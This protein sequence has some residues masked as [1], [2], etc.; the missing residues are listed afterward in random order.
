[1]SNI[2]TKSLACLF[3]F[4][5]ILA[6]CSSPSPSGISR[7]PI[8]SSAVA[9]AT[10]SPT[11]S[12]VQHTEDI[13]YAYPMD[14]N[15]P[16][17][18][19]DVYAPSEIDANPVVVFL[20]GLNAN[21]NAHERE[22]RAL[23]ERGVLVFTINWPTPNSDLAWENNGRD[24]RMMAEAHACAIRYAR[25]RATDFGGDPTQ[26]IMV[27]FSMG[28]RIGITAALAGDELPIL[29]KEFAATRGGPPSQIECVENEASAKV[30][31][32]VGIGGRYNSVNYLKAMDAELWEIVS[33]YAHIGR[34]PNQRIRLVLGE[35]DTGVSSEI[36]V[37]FNQL[38]IDAGYDSSLTMWDGAHRVPAELTADLVDD[39]VGK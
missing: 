4:L 28:A 14:T 34:S 3:T 7:N 17:L 21:K 15:Q 16:A 31:A 26:L 29:W 24:F 23:A 10:L 33:P 25:A 30:M 8:D 11:P 9:R 35:R 18:L 13:I 39:V 1:M 19:L 36:Q 37:E 32:F 12:Y 6:A 20:H 38:L 22:S 2:M 27:A 5:P